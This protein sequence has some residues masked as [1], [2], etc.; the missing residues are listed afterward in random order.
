MSI[1]FA[2]AGSGEC[3]AVARVLARRRLSIR[4]A[5]NDVDACIS[6]D[7]LLVSSL[8]HF[9]L[10]GL[11]AAREA[12]RLAQEAR[13]QQDLERYHHWLAICRHLDRRMAARMEAACQRAGL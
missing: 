8:R 10:H 11:G 1:R 9:A 4:D 6:D 7:V 3:L 5:A 2:A 12:G 13:N